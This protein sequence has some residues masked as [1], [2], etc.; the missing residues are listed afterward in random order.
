MAREG[1]DT[2][3]G[4]GVLEWHGNLEEDSDTD[5]SE[6]L[7]RRVAEQKGRGQSRERKARAVF[8]LTRIAKHRAAPV[9]ALALGS[10]DDRRLVVVVNAVQLPSS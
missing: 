6:G 8:G 2:G 10:D 1:V 5:R 7:R 4:S 9:L 3:F